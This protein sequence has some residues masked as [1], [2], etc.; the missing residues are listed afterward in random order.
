MIL[1]ID[2]IFS[3]PN[4]DTGLMEWFFNA[5]EG[6]FGPYRSKNEASLSLKAFIKHCIKMDYD[7]GRTNPEQEQFSLIPSTYPEQK[8]FPLI[9]RTE[10]A[11]RG[12]VNREGHL[13]I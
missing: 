4:P 3:F 10:Y 9:P 5:R 7:G 1:E 11:A 8:Q 6:I 2:R 13:T 12:F